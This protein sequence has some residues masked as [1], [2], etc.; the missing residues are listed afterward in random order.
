[1]FAVNFCELDYAANRHVGNDGNKRKPRQRHAR[2]SGQ[3]EKREQHRQRCIS[4]ADPGNADGDEQ[5]HRYHRIHDRREQQAGVDAERPKAEVSRDDVDDVDHDADQ[6]S[7]AE[8]GRFSGHDQELAEALTC[9]CF[10]G[11]VGVAEYL[12][13]RGI[14]PSGGACTGLDAIHWAVNRGQLEA[15]RLLIRHRVP[16][17][18]R[19]MYGGTALGT[20]V[21]SAINEPRADHLT[22]IQDLLT[23]D[24]RV[25]EAGCPT[26]NDDIDALLLPELFT[27]LR[28][29][30]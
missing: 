30:C 2:R 16:L 19:S 28:S 10:N 13:S 9:A 1:M 24:S 7:L 14:A 20:A 4:H 18:S 5:H 17:E 8:Q 3:P 6:K 29:R 23:A 21:W 25:R 27:W 15:V 12:L 26:G 22:I 11:R